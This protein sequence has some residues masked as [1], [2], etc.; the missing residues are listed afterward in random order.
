MELKLVPLG[1]APNNPPPKKEVSIA[2]EL[3]EE[4]SD[5]LKSK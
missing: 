2:P 3:H 5:K 1:Y 4:F